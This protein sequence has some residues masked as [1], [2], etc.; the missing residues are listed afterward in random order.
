MSAIYI[1]VESFIGCY[2]LCNDVQCVLVVPLVEVSSH[3]V[4]SVTVRLVTSALEMVP[5]QAGVLMAGT[6][7]GVSTEV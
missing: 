5:V 2:V 1:F 4:I 3:V 6:V 7:T